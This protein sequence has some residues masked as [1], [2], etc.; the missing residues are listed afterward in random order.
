MTSVDENAL[1]SLGTIWTHS[2]RGNLDEIHPPDHPSFRR[3]GPEH[4]SLI[5]EVGGEAS[6]EEISRRFSAQGRCYTAWVENHIAAYG[7]VSLKHEYV[8]ELGWSVQLEPC[9]AYIWD[10]YTLPA[11]RG[12][13][14][15]AALLVNILEALR[16]DDFCRAWIG[17]SLDNIPSHRGIDRAGFLRVADML[18]ASENG[19]RRVWVEGYP[20]VPEDLVA[21]SRRVFL[22][23]HRRPL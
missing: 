14:L 10:C 3:L 19:L 11:F 21:Q 2:L 23:H 12:K 8:G 18:S 15:Y 16:A 17:A 1:Q 4:A 9:E 13:H 22:N 5:A 20:G 6:M 7:W